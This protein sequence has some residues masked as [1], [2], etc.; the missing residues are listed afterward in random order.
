MDRM[1]I[2][3]NVTCCY[4]CPDRWVDV[5]AGRNCHTSCEKYLSQLAEQTKQKDEA[6]RKKSNEYQVLGYFRELKSIK[7]KKQKNMLG[8]KH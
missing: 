2:G 5:E 6:R 3:K 1:I 4:N 7:L 8:V